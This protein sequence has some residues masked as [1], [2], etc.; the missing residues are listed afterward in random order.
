MVLDKKVLK[1]LKAGSAFRV[2]CTDFQGFHRNDTMCLRVLDKETV[3]LVSYHKASSGEADGAGYF[4][5]L[6][7]FFLLFVF[8]DG[9]AL[10]FVLVVLVVI[11]TF[12]LALFIFNFSVR[13]NVA[14]ER[15]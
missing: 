5:F 3:C 2:K 4:L 1:L 7:F 8:L 11:L 9:F 13:Q 14:L 6:F 12:V 10:D 15:N